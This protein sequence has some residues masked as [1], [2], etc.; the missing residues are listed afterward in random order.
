MF[1]HAPGTRDVTAASP[2][3]GDSYM[4]AHSIRNNNQISN[5]DQTRYEANFYTVDHEC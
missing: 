1:G 3:I 2:N 4:R 5:N